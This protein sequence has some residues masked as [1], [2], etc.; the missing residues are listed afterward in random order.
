MPIRAL[1]ALVKLREVEPLAAHDYY[2]SLPDVLMDLAEQNPTRPDAQRLAELAHSFS[3]D[4]LGLAVLGGRTLWYE[5]VTPDM[6]RPPDVVSVS[7]DVENYFVLL[8]TACDIMGDVVRHLGIPNNRRGQ[9]PPES[10]HK[11]N[12]WAKANASKLLPQFR[13]IAEDLPWFNQ[14]NAIRTKLVHRGYGSVTFTNRLCLSFG[15][16]QPELYVRIPPREKRVRLEPLV[17]LLKRLTRSVVDFSEDLAAAVRQQEGVANLSR[18]HVLNGVYVPALHHLDAYQVPIESSQAVVVA[19]CLVTLGDYLT[20]TDLGYPSGYRWVLLTNLCERLG[21]AAVQISKPGFTVSGRPVGEWTFMF[22]HQDRPFA[23]LACDRIATESLSRVHSNLRQLVREFDIDG[24]I[25][26]VREHVPSDK[27]KNPKK[28]PSNVIVDDNPQT[29]AQEA[30]G[31]LLRRRSK[32][33]QSGLMRIER[34]SITAP[35]PPRRTRATTPGSSRPSK[36]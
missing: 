33:I 27:G 7:V 31:R 26:V 11:L 8:Q 21:V 9:A 19:T 22:R 25:L 29:A 5:A 3:H 18:T 17:P 4:I 12:N 2:L 28:L 36:D 30:A 34:K 13:F 35:A 23:I 10:F 14:L 32:P 16:A 24:V 15:L 1:Q 6:S 20:A